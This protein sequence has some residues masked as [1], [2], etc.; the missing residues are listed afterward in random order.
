MGLGTAANVAESGGSLRVSH[1]YR[2]GLSPAPNV[3]YAKSWG[4][5]PYFGNWDPEKPI[6]D[7]LSGTSSWTRKPRWR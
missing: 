5:L 3:V 2:G 7:A 4:A 1:D 6:R